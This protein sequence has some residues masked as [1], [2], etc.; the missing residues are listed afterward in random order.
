MQLTHA[1]GKSFALVAVCGLFAC[2]TKA[3]A[4]PEKPS[5]AATAAAAVKVQ[6]PALDPR[7]LAYDLG[8][9]QAP[10]SNP[11]SPEKIA[12]GHQLFFDKR[13]SVDGSRSCYSCHLNEDGGGGHDP[14]AIGAEGKV[15]A[16]HSPVIWN[17]GYL[18]RLYWDGR[19]DSLE[20]QMKGAW[21]GGNMGV[22]KDN[23]EKKAK[24]IGKIKGYQP[25]FAKVFP[26]EGATADT[27]AQAVSAYER[28]LVCN[29]TAYDR[30]AKGDGRALSETQKVGLGLFM[31]KAACVSC[32]APPHFS[33]AYSVPSGTYFNTGLG[34]KGV[35]EDKVDV[36]RFKVTESEGDWAAFKV[37]TLRNVRRTPPY[38]HDG[39]VATLDE[40][41]KFMASGG[42]AN[43]NKTPLLSDRKLS[44]EELGA[45]V[46]FL[47]ALDCDAKL[48]EPKLPE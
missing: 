47:S 43:K 22:G 18:P 25:A 16:R 9:P 46:E 30:F 40:A 5:N 15:L 17:V 36:G 29:N 48:E 24:E 39:S 12:L 37:P 27:I 28:T 41:V 33:S 13:L 31:G 23:L 44:S 14:L 1:F 19:A 2:E 32:H 8:L 10:A 34:T 7:S 3:P 26:K 21:A 6:P 35:A 38:F 42:H 45:V 20:A 11:P 4:K